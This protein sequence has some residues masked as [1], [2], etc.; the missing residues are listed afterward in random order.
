MR[1]VQIIVVCPPSSPRIMRM[2][3]E[4]G[5]G[6]TPAVQV[7]N[8]RRENGARRHAARLHDAPPLSQKSRRR[9][10]HQRAALQPAAHSTFAEAGRGS[11]CNLLAVAERR[12]F[13][14]QGDGV[15]EEN[16]PS[17]EAGTDAASHQAKGG[18]ASCAPSGRLQVGGGMNHC[19]LCD[20][21]Y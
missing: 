15:R 4:A 1:T 9:R 5:A 19:S 7:T 17:I 21:C 18:G 12:R 6:T 14:R 3:I 16:A 8:S 2:L 10:R 13:R 11:S 20:R